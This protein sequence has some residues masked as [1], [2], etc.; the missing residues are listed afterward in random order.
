[1]DGFCRCK[2]PVAIVVEMDRI[3][4]PGGWAIIRDKVEILD[5]LEGI[6]RSLHWEI[7][8]TYNHEKEGIMCVQK[9]IWRP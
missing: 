8:M 1:M 3:V 2:Q 6:F 5:P 7:R 9:T 4:R